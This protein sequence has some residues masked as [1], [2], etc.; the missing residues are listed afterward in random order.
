MDEIRENGMRVAG[1]YLL[2]KD[3]IR[4]NKM[5]DGICF[6]AIM[7]VVALTAVLSIISIWRG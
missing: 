7:G 1:E 6:L 4:F 3:N 2:R 5:I